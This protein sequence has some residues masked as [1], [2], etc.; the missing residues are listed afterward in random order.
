MTEDSYVHQ[1]HQVFRSCDTRGDGLLGRDE[2]VQLCHKLQLT[3]QQ[4]WY[5]SDRL[6]GTDILIKIDF[7]EFKEAFVDLLTQEVEEVGE[8]RVGDVTICEA[9][10]LADR[11]KVIDRNNCS[12]HDEESDEE[13][14]VVLPNNESNECREQEI[15]PVNNTSSSFKSEN[16]HQHQKQQQRHQCEHHEIANNSADN[17]LTSV[18]EYL[19]SIWAHLNVGQDGYLNSEELYS[20]CVGI[21]MTDMSDEMVNQLFITLDEDGDGR[22]SFDELLQGMFRSQ[23]ESQQ[24][25]L[26]DDHNKQQ[27]PKT[28]QQTQQQNGTQNNDGDDGNTP[29]KRP[30]NNNRSVGNEESSYIIPSPARSVIPGNSHASKQHIS[31]RQE[32][33]QHE[34]LSSSPL[35]PS[36]LHSPL[37]SPSHSNQ[38]QSHPR[39]SMPYHLNHLHSH[40]RRNSQ[41]IFPHRSSLPPEAH[42]DRVMENILSNSFYLFSL[43]IN[44]TG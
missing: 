24:Q 5:I 25:P 12:S 41:H 16:G 1:L 7:D 11:K 4:S 30:K 8:E 34:V 38:Y 2:V 32:F 37:S 31:R 42:I 20:V 27:Q 15:R 43:D 33:R 23:Q 40:Q 39:H 26:N 28:T 22:V 21:G 6:I 44:G 3:E 17:D 9:T 13:L 35:S 19:R 18:E 10:S 14:I 29:E 36:L